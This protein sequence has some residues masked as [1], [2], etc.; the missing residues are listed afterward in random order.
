MSAIETYYLNQAVGLPYFSGPTTQQ[1]HGLGG[2]FGRLFRAVVP[3]FK[4]AAPVLTSA[5]K[6]V[7]KEAVRSGANVLSDV[8]EGE[9][10]KDALSN[11]SR[12]GARRLVRK[13]ANKLRAVTTSP[14]PIYRKRS[15]APKDIF[16]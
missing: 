5:A 6:T 9:D 14:E 13:G 1:G 7:A 3:L 10:I 8:A 12:E 2:I 11:R 4:K 15:R 16:S